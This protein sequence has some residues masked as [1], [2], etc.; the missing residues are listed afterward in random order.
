MSDS[1][2]DL[3]IKTSRRLEGLLETHYGAE[4]RGLHEK[5]AAGPASSIVQPHSRRRPPAVEE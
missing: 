3:A 5:L 1:D 2:I 4:G